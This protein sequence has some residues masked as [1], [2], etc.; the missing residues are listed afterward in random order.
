M[1]ATSG[2]NF[3]SAYPDGSAGQ[4]LGTPEGLDW[5]FYLG[6]APK[7]PYNRGRFLATYR[8]FWDYS[9][10]TITDYG[11]H[12]FE[13]V[14]QSW[15]RHA[16][17]VVAAGGRSACATAAKCRTSC[18]SPT[19]TRLRHELRGQLPERPRTRGTYAGMKYYNARGELDRP[20]ASLSTEPTGPCLQTASA[21]RF[22]PKRDASS[23]SG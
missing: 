22:T 7:V 10:G 23:A 4:R 8:L 2:V 15:Q 17:N 3:S 12:R 14:H 1:S 20:T 18:K 11:T 21:T 13:T 5:D 16:S 9:G 19:N 6:P